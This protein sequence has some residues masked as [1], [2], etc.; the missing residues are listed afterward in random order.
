MATSL[1]NSEQ[2]GIKILNGFQDMEF[3]FQW[4][5]WYLILSIWN[6][7]FS[8]IIEVPISDATPFPILLFS[9]KLEN[10]PSKN[11]LEK[12]IKKSEVLN[13][14]NQNLSLVMEVLI[15]EIPFS[16]FVIQLQYPNDDKVMHQ[17]CAR[18]RIYITLHSSPLSQKNSYIY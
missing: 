5:P 11:Q 3:P 16:N 10:M 7:I 15:S 18:K 13:N 17:L 6:Y 8:L 1:S 14:K 2:Q 4:K 9:S 12:G